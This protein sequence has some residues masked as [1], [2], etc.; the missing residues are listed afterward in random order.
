M[1]AY[2]I[3]MAIIVFALAYRFYG[4]FMNRAMGIDDRRATPAV[5]VNDGLD[6]CPAK[7]PLLFGHHFASIAG[8]GLI[9]GPIMAGRTFGW[10]PALLWIVIGAV[11]IGGVQDFTSLVAS[12]RHRAQS[13]AQI[14]Q[15]YMSPMAH[16]LFL[17]FI[18]LALI[19]MIIVF[20]DLTSATFVTGPGVG[21]ISIAYTI[22][23][24]SLGIAVSLYRV[25][26]LKGSLVVVPLL[27]LCLWWGGAHPFNP[28]IFLNSL[29]DT[30]DVL[31]M[32]YCFMASDLPVW[33]LLQPRD[34]LSSFLLFACL[35][36]GMIGILGGGWAGTLVIEIPFLR[37]LYDPQIGFI[38]PGLF[39][40]LACGA[41]SGFHSIVASGTTAKQLSEESQARCIGYGAMLVEGLLACMALATVMIMM[42]LTG[43]ETPTQIFAIGISRFFHFFGIPRDWSM[44]FGLLT[45]STFLLTTLDTGTRLGR[46]AFSELLGLKGRCGMIGATLATLILPTYCLL[47]ESAGPDGIVV[48]AWKMIWPVFG[49]SNQLLGALALL[50]VTV[51]LKKTGRPY[52]FTLIP[53]FFMISV[54]LVALVQLIV[55]YQWSLIDVIAGALLVLALVLGV[56]A[57]RAFSKGRR[58]GLENNLI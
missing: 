33:F 3:L 43:E 32:I 12:I 39:I 50:V 27:F 13:V 56:E 15:E 2:L 51:W 42:P 5:T 26:L 44:M 20:A 53:T 9:I 35:A 36:G 34:Y 58:E 7:R 28:P 22:L 11:F 49:A 48:P 8:A 17:V 31:L 52:V 18:W 4:R 40:V 37:T 23:A 30:W 19:Y 55:K 45:L 24:V 16:K 29:Q 41:C 54:T 57:L 14:A 46:Y 25:G 38:F 10:G 21:T 1:I 47:N 6:Y